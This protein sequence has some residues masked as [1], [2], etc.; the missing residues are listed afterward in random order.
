MIK[1]KGQTLIE[2][3]LMLV[4][5]IPFFTLLFSVFYLIYSKEIVSYIHYKTL[6]CT[7]ELNRTISSCSN[8]SSQKIQDLLFFHKNLK[9]KLKITN[10]KT[11]I[12][13]SGFFM[14]FNMN[15]EKSIKVEVQ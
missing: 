2:T 11:T 8:W 1:Q 10:K 14:G 4:V 13:T 6:F 15:F 5:L 3:A 9:T 7:E 12:K